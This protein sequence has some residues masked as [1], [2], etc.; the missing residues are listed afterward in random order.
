MHSR[1][2]WKIQC[3]LCCVVYILLPAIPISSPCRGG[4]TFVESCLHFL[5]TR[6]L[7][8]SQE[9]FYVNCALHACR[10][11][12]RS[13]IFWIIGMY[14]SNYWIYTQY[15]I[16]HH[17]E[18]MTESNISLSGSGFAS[19]NLCRINLWLNPGYLMM[20]DSYINDKTCHQ[21]LP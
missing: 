7:E 10:I 18:F 11:M 8:K 21:I 5:K 16:T 15:K 9:T 2:C 1:S 4:G 6:V 17:H 12:L 14:Q 19:I 20:I 13:I 3:I